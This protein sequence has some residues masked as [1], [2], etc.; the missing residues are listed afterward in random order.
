MPSR[1]P[2]LVA[3]AVLA[4]VAAAALALA[5]HSSPAGAIAHGTPAPAGAYGF[6]ARLAFTGVPAPDG[7]T[8]DSACSGALVAPRW[9]LT[10]GHCF[11]DAARR[12]VSGRVPYRTSTITVGRADLSAGGGAVRKVIEVRQALGG[13]DV[14]LARLDRP[15]TVVGT[16]RLS[17]TAPTVGEVVRLAGWGATGSTDPAPSTILHTGTFTVA[18]LTGT[19]AGMTGL[20]PAADTS[21]CAYDSGAPYF[22]E[23]PQGPQ[24]VAVESSGPDCP[25]TEAE[26]TYRTDVLAG[27]VA[28]QLAADQHPPG[29]R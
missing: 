26:T 1:R 6:A 16:L 7:T 14:A 23:T 13:A 15:V 25:H 17:R 22:R 4:P 18:T 10:A 29:R 3:A 9:V 24:L 21:A 8:Y 19:V 5:V 12:P 20:T 11:H 27:W 2:R 28:R